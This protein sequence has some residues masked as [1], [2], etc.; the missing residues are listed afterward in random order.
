MAARRGALSKLISP[1]P[2]A[3]FVDRYWGRETLFV[4]GDTSKI[5]EIFGRALGWEDFYDVAG[6]ESQWTH[7]GFTLRAATLLCGSGSMEHRDRTGG[8]LPMVGVDPVQAPRMLA[9]GIPV[10]LARAHWFSRPIADFLR[11]FTDDLVGLRGLDCTLT[12]NVRGPGVATHFDAFPT[13]HLQLVGRKRWTVSSVP[14]EDWPSLPGVVDSRGHKE[15]IDPQGRRVDEPIDRSKLVH[16]DVKPGD[17]LFLPAG[18]W[19]EARVEGEPVLALELLFNRFKISELLTEVLAQRIERSIGRHDA[20]VFLS[21]RTPAWSLP[22]EAHDAFGAAIA[23]LRAELERLDPTD[24]DLHRALKRQAGGFV[25]APE[26]TLTF[27]RPTGTERPGAAGRKG[28]EL[29]PDRHLS[30]SARGPMTAAPAPGPGGE[31]LVLVQQG[32]ELR[33]DG[34]ELSSFGA[35]LVESRGEAFRAGDTV[36]WTDGPEYT[37]DVVRSVLVRLLLAGFVELRDGS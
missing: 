22:D 6:R 28:L 3:E 4:P 5:E 19:H 15:Y 8:F 1:V 29:T 10:T 12:T 37:W 20:P 21:E 27:V 17:V 7:R 26:P 34:P 33:L 30:V 32:I 14:E 23:A 36:G 16:Y 9:A 13:L 18:T 11:G 31:T 2:P 35:R 24:P 25:P